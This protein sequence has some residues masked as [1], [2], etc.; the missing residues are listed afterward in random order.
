MFESSGA[1]PLSEVLLV[2]EGSMPLGKRA[3]YLVS[4][5][6][7][8]VSGSLGVGALPLFLADEVSMVVSKWATSS[9]ERLRLSATLLR[10]LVVWMFRS[11][12]LLMRARRR[13]FVA[14][15]GVRR[16]D[17]KG[18]VDVVVA[19]GDRGMGSGE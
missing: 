3:L 7:M 15:V 10:R 13:S 18:R 4:R 17:R 11:E 9:R 16:L 1:F 12:V 19:L 14:M 6:R 5:S 8:R 2:L